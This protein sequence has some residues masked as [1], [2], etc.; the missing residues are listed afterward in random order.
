MDDTNPYEYAKKQLCEAA[1]ELNLEKGIV[2]VLS[3]PIRE[4]TVRFPVKMDSGHIKMFTGYR[5]Q[6]SE[7][8]GPTKGGIR[9]HPEVS[10]DEIRALAMWM[11][12][13]CALVNLPYGGAK[14]GVV[15]DPKK[16][17]LGE[18]ERITRRY[19]SEIGI[20][21]GPEKDILAPDVNTNPQTMAWI[22]DTYSMNVGY[23][24]PGVV[25]GKPIDIGGSEGRFE[26]TGRGCV[27]TII[28]AAKKLG[29]NLKGA[30]VAIQGFGNV[31]PVAAR[32]IH[33]A[34]LKSSL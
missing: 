16:L 13:K 28:E 30:T 18:M 26:A 33:E 5:I 9:Y 22:M 3:T 27:I 7:T 1:E 2:E 10:L 25:T 15:C 20:I 23:A 12:W 4:L 11:T 24:V 17:S 32:L 14:G 21:I 6:H 19:I 8:R 29:L 34:G 31:G